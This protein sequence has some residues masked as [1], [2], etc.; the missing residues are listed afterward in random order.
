M[1]KIFVLLFIFIILIFSD[2]NYDLTNDAIRFRVIANS[3]SVTDI[4]MKEKVVS[5]I[6]KMI[7]KSNLNKEQTRDNVIKNMENI[8]SSIHSL[9]EKNNYSKKYNI[10]YG[11][12]Y[13]PKKE[14]NGKI[15]PEGEYESLVIEIGDAKG[16]NYWCI[17][18]PQLCMVDT[19][20]TNSDLKYDFKFLKVFKKFF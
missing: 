7:F 15:F 17:M 4:L 13:F 6:S 3:N 19:S 1:K 12:N 16:N 11:M 18:Y 2:K 14:Y 20:N 9:F 10:I 8:D 5:E